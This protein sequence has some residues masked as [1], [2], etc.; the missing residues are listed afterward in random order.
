MNGAGFDSTPPTRHDD[1]RGR[2]RD[3]GAV[4]HDRSDPRGLELVE[5][6]GG[7]AEPDGGPRPPPGAGEDDFLAGQGGLGR[8][9]VQARALEDRHLHRARR[10]AA[11]LHDDADPPLGSRLGH[12][13]RDLDLETR[14]RGLEHLGLPIVEEH[15]VARGVGGKARAG[16]RRTLADA[17]ACRLDAVQANATAEESQG[18]ED[19]GAE[20]DAR[21]RAEADRT[22]PL[23]GA[24]RPA[25]G[26][27][28]GRT[29]AARRR[30]SR[31]AGRGRA[32]RGR[33]LDARA[34]GAP[35]R[36]DGR[37]SAAGTGSGGASARLGERLGLGRDRE[38]RR[39]GIGGS[40][41]KKRH[42]WSGRRWQGGRP[43]GGQRRPLRGTP[44]DRLQGRQ[45]EDRGRDRRD[46]LQRKRLR[47]D[48]LG[49]NHGL[50]QRLL[51][52]E[53]LVG[54]RER[55]QAAPGLPA[56]R[57]VGAVRSPARWAPLPR[58]PNRR[59]SSR[60]RAPR[61]TRPPEEAGPGPEP[62]RSPAGLFDQG[63]LDGRGRLR[64]RDEAPPG[65]SPRKNGSSS[66]EAAAAAGSTKPSGS[67]STHG[68][69]WHWTHT[70]SGSCGGP[71]HSTSPS[72][73]GAWPSTAGRVHVEPARRVRVVHDRLV[74]V[75]PDPGVDGADAGEVHD[76]V[77]VGIGA[78]Q[79][80]GDDFLG[81]V[82]AAVEGAS[83]HGERDEAQL[84]VGHRW[85]LG[86]SITAGQGILVTPPRR[87]AVARG[88]P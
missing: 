10:A 7:V 4:R 63:L 49:L 68:A 34:R 85:I 70:L 52:D 6:R 13:L 21:R 27:S 82:A 56:R 71:S 1:G 43:L 64:R 72:P 23:G 3:T 77:A 33:G 47:L 22:E 76:Q 38:G 69:K 65:A 30:R 28:S 48:E 44:R 83:E 80:L 55:P 5:L 25:T 31:R 32:T 24:P 50:R 9:A 59:R 53:E 2:A 18:D 35:R 75:R 45:L 78:D 62:R 39:L 87:R 74:E 12:G 60:R 57:T 37:G 54:G 20:Q 40:L 66:V 73:M 88:T 84:R 51:G 17:Q 46:G 8:D 14:R 41:R 79:D 11:V 16:Q 19:D 58:S 15:R 67:T 29:R 26:G 86:T 81:V 36:L 42:R 61:A